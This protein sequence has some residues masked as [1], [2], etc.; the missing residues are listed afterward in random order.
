MELH[1][2]P[3]NMGSFLK[4][5]SATIGC[6]L[7]SSTKTLRVETARHVTVTSRGMHTLP[8]IVVVAGFV[9]VWAAV[10]ID[11]WTTVGG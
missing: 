2:A 3:A 1:G 4:L 6:V 10:S 5:G 9:G 7:G 8:S 11:C